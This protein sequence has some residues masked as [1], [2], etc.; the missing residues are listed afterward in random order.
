[1]K[2]PSGMCWHIQRKGYIQLQVTC[3]QLHVEKTLRH[4]WLQK[5]VR[6]IDKITLNY[7]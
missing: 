6:N 2:S 7:I 1:M 3:M 4:G 5:H